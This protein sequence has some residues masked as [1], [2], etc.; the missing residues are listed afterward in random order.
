MADSTIQQKLT[1]EVLGTFVLVFFGCGSVVYAGQAGQFSIETIGLTFGIAVM[2][3]VYAFGRVS[4]AHFNPAVS[5]GAAVGG[6]M[7]WRH[8]GLYVVAQ[9]VGAVL[10]ALMLFV[11]MVG[12][13]AAGLASPL[14]FG[15]VWEAGPGSG[16]SFSR[17]RTSAHG[18]GYA[19]PDK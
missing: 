17:P 9:L 5:V 12:A 14:L 18:P 6:R 1:A 11:L 3:M 19:S 15:R 4:G 2:V 8:V 13:A 10:G 7:A 16:I